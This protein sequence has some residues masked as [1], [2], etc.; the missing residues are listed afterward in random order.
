MR[1]LIE[2]IT[3][4]TKERDWEKYHTP[5]NLA[6]ALSVEVSELLEHFQWASGEESKAPSPEK[7]AAIRDEIGDVMIYLVNLATK[8]DID[9][10]EAAKDKLVKAAEKYPVE[11]ARKI[12]W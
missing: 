10:L 1:E 6:M 7:R 8:L 5:K 4:F 11:A 12:K 9:P 2:N 3:K